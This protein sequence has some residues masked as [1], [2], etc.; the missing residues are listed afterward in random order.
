[1]GVFNQNSSFLIFLDLLYR[2]EKYDIAINTF[3][4]MRLRIEQRCLPL[5]ADLVTLVFASSYKLVS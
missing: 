4:Q 1:M 2:R 5:N 3:K